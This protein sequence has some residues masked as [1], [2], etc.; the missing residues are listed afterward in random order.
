MNNFQYFP[1]PKSYQDTRGPSSQY[2]QKRP[3][4]QWRVIILSLVVL[5]FV[6]QGEQT[7][8]AASF[9]L[10]QSPSAVYLPSSTRPTITSPDTQQFPDPPKQAQHLQQGIEL[11]N[12]GHYQNALVQFSTANSD[13]LKAYILYFRGLS[14][15]KLARFQGAL[16]SFNDA[17][18]SPGSELLR[19]DI[20]LLCGLCLEYLGREKAALAQYQSWLTGSGSSLRAFV[21]LRAA[22]CASRS[23][24]YKRA[25]HLIETCL[26]TYP[27][28]GSASAAKNLGELLYKQGKIRLNPHSE[29]IRHAMLRRLI[30]KGR[31]REAL[32]L[33]DRLLKTTN[34]PN[35][36]LYYKGKALYRLRKTQQSIA[37][38]KRVVEEA[39]QSGLTPWA[40]YHQAKGY[41][42][43]GNPDDEANME[44]ALRRVLALNPS[45]TQVIHASRKLLMLFLIEHARFN[46][47]LEQADIL[48]KT[49]G[50]Q[51]SKEVK[52]LGGLL[53]L[54]LGHPKQAA[55]RLTNFLPLASNAEEQSAAHF[56]LGKALIQSHT[57]QRGASHLK[58]AAL[59]WANTYY[60]YESARLL[61][62]LR[63]NGQIDPHTVTPV[64]TVPGTPRCPDEAS[65]DPG[66]A[67]TT[68]ASNRAYFLESVGLYSLALPEWEAAS[69]ANPKNSSLACQSARLATRM[70]KH[71]DAARPLWRTFG[72]C[73]FRGSP[74]SLMPIRSILYPQKYVSDIIANVQ[75]TNIDPTIISSLIRQESYFNSSAVSGAGAIGLMQ[76]MPETGKTIAS[77]LHDSTFQ[78]KKLFDPA[79]NLRYGIT[80]FK[81]RYQRYNAIIPTLCSYNAGFKKAD[82]W[83]TNLGH[84]DEDLFIAFIP[85]TETRNY[86]RRILNNAAMY[87]R[88]W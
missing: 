53:H 66:I 59:T 74:Q 29:A 18:A 88:L 86:V 45:D 50:P 9:N 58:Y 44:A 12:N 20:Q 32:Q 24:Q 13:T 72:G 37:T 48:V 79:F 17:T 22:V 39:P 71:M 80:Y 77:W 38:L 46:E 7:A 64:H 30:D 56:F 52:W 8:L 69:R 87:R 26:K 67:A 57:V 70:N 2:K 4:P 51:T 31:G 73:L 11:Y 10:P 62:Q 15:F 82:V 25:S 68:P 5:A 47:A 63:D 55:I 78:R 83:N 1:F 19:R 60:G 6:F 81:R 36:I 14:E 49:A 35:R 34:D 85:Y 3:L 75:G 28:T 43:Y 84:L 76:V 23:G 54:A 33:A 16:D 21:L 41:W 40:L 61:A 42:R 27:W 65:F